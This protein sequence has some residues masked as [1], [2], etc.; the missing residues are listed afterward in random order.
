LVKSKSVSDG[1]G[2]TFILILDQGEDAFKSITDFANT[3]RK[4]PAPRYG[5]RRV[6]AAQGRLVRSCG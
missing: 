6:F 3:R 1:V 4:S 5:E 2:R